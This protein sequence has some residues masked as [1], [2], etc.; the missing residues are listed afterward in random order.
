MAKSTCIKCG[1]QS[2]DL[3][4]LIRASCGKGGNHEAYEGTENRK[5]TCIKCGYQSSDLP[6]LIRA[7]CGKGGNHEPA[8]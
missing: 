6:S 4:S 2:S 7:S 5:Y 3:S 8:R 1:Y